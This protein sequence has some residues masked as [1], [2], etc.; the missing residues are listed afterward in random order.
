MTTKTPI[1]PWLKQHLIDTGRWS[2]DGAYRKARLRHHSCGLIVLHGLDA[3]LA[4]GVATCDPHWL[5]PL[6]EALALLANRDT[7]DYRPLTQELDGPRGHRR[8]TWAPATNQGSV[9]V[10]PAHACGQPP[11]PHFDIPPTPTKE[12]TDAIPY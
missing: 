2:T 7:Y 1:S 12:A 6:G 8:I 5:T 3:D 9:R 10:L 11:L 4:A